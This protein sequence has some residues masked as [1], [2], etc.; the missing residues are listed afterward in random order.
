MAVVLL[1][2]PSSPLYVQWYT[3]TIQSEP[4]TEVTKKGLEGGWGEVGSSFGWHFLP[5]HSPSS[6]L[7]AKVTITAKVTFDM[8]KGAE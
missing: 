2:N 7:T 6:P 8:G 4:K 3:H 5:S 1:P